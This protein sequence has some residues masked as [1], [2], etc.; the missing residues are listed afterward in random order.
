[1]TNGRTNNGKKPTK[2]RGANPKIKTDGSP[3]VSSA[4]LKPRDWT[5]SM[6]LGFKNTHN[7]KAIVESV[8]AHREV[9]ARLAKARGWIITFKP[10]GEK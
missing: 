5:S 2:K 4:T 6:E 7:A 8:I 3:Q 9:I 1:M 10:A